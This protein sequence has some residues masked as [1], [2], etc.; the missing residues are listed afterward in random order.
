MAIDNISRRSYSPCYL[1]MLH[2]QKYWISSWE[3][4]S[5]KNRTH[6]MWGIP[7]EVGVSD[8]RMPRVLCWVTGD[9]R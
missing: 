7:A 2:L 3:I 1:G 5:Q 9:D 8:A 6:L 4:S